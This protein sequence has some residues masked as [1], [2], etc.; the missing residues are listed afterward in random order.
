MKILLLAGNPRKNGYTQHLTDLFVKGVA[1]AGAELIHRDLAAAD[2]KP[3]IGC[4]SC[5]VTSPGQCIFHDDMD[6]LIQD[7]LAAD[8]VMCATPLNSFSI[9]TCLKNFFDRTLPLAQPHF[10][11]SPRGLVRNSLRFPER[12]PKKIAMLVV[13]A[14]KGPENFVAVHEMLALYAN[15]LS[16]DIAGE[17]IRPESFL[18]P[19]SLAKPMTIKTIE[20]AMVRAGYEL[21]TAG[22]ISEETM[23]KAAT[24]LSSDLVN[25][26]KY[27]TIYWEHALA[28]GAQFRDLDQ[29]QKNVTADVRILLREMARSIDPL[30]TAHLHAT[31]LFEFGNKNIYFTLCV[32]HGACTL[33]E[34]KTEKFDLKVSCTTE[35]WG[36]VFMRQINMRDALMSR[37]ILLEGDKF[38]FSR[39]DRYFPP[40]V[41]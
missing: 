17:L 16:L 33:C 39:L 19:F 30:A 6:R 28:M 20:A 14:F 21:A 12:W 22:K 4:Y 8:I 15:A 7:F 37:Q 32:D 23:A 10:E 25:F 18:L 26:N 34:E 40:P 24:P 27:S 13:G 1:D 9:S 36:R 31:I 3:C 5:W 41:M 35:V 11:N 38:L 29:L 2:I